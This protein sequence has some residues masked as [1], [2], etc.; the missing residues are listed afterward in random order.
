[1]KENTKGLHI[2]LS[3]KDK[4]EWDELLARTQKKVEKTLTTKDFLLILMEY[5]KGNVK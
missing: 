4:I 2:T 1:M 3:I 5:Y